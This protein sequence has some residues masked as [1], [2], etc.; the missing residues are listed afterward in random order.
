MQPVV[1][2]CCAYAPR[3]N[4]LQ[5]TIS[6]KRAL[7][8]STYLMISFLASFDDFISITRI[9]LVMRGIKMFC[10]KGLLMRK[11]TNWRPFFRLVR[12]EKKWKGN[13]Q[14]S[15]QDMRIEGGAI[16]NNAK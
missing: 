15:E 7:S 3:E 4:V 5:Y 16:Q 6:R 14:N 12:K 13:D 1:G 8:I 2:S 11:S 10:G 9:E